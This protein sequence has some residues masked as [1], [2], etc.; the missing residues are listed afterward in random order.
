MLYFYFF[1]FTGIQIFEI[2]FNRKLNS[3]STEEC[4]CLSSTRTQNGNSQQVQ[5]W[6]FRKGTTLTYLFPKML[7]FNEVPQFYFFFIIIT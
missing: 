7:P 3:L 1:F 4:V 6:I 5:H 2:H